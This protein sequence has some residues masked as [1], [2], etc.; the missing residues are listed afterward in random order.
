VREFGDDSPVVFS[1]VK[2]DQIAAACHFGFISRDRFVWYKP[3]YEP[4][5]A[6]SRPR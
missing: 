2:V 6:S 1:A 3:S 4:Q 5:L